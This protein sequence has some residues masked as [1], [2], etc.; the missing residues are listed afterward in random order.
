MPLPLHDITRAGKDPGV[1]EAVQKI[2][3]FL[4]RNHSD[5]RVKIELATR[6]RRRLL[7]A[8]QQSVCVCVCAC[9][10]YGLLHPVLPL[11][12]GGEP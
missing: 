1:E 12:G 9:V 10:W 3:V 6:H 8:T 7:T 2:Q 5:E 4:C 11:V